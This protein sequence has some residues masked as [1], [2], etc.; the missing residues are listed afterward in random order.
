MGSK[1]PRAA[2]AIRL[3]VPGRPSTGCRRAGN[4]GGR[5]KPGGERETR[6]GFVRR[7]GKYDGR[8]AGVHRTMARLTDRS[9][10]Q[11]VPPLVISVLLDDQ[12]VHVRVPRACST[13]GGKQPRLPE[14]RNDNML[15]HWQCGIHWFREKSGISLH[16]VHQGSRAYRVKRPKRV[17]RGR[18]IPSK[19]QSCSWSGWELLA[20]VHY[21][22]SLPVAVAR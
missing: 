8:A 19:L 12:H 15:W 2:P 17:R 18:S 10:R 22:S 6:E 14:C 3:L 9:R 1:A 4:F 16:L 5:P 21:S 11:K 20:V 13:I 7:G